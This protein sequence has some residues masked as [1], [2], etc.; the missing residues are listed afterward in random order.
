MQGYTE[1]IEYTCRH[2]LTQ[3][4]YKREMQ[5]AWSKEVKAELRK[6]AVAAAVEITG[7]VIST[8][9]DHGPCQPPCLVARSKGS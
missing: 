6:R 9:R 2:E 7:Q 3:I 8:F 4:D 1:K 5:I